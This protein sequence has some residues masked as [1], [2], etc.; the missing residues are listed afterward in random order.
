M[1]AQQPCLDDRLEVTD[2][3]LAAWLVLN[4]CE[5]LECRYSPHAGPLGCLMIFCDLR[6]HELHEQYLQH[7]ARA[8]LW[9]FR[10]VFNRIN[11]C[12]HEAKQRYE[13]AR[14]GTEGQIRGVPRRGAS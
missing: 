7:G 1:S 4:G 13:Q 12:V 3:Y 14:R 2:A 6:I 10:T 8:E 11:R 5:P 9:E